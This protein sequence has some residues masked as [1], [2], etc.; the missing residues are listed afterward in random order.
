MTKENAQERY[1]VMKKEF[2]EE[3]TSLAQEKFPGMGFLLYATVK[4]DFSAPVEGDIDIASQ[5]V[6]FRLSAGDLAA[7]VSGILMKLPKIKECV[8]SYIEQD[9]LGGKR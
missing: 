4:Q 1:D 7:L 3:V 6:G 9:R 8:D 5:I 2:C